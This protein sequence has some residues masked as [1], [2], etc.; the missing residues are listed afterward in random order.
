MVLSEPERKVFESPGGCH[1]DRVEQRAPRQ[2]R[3]PSDLTDAER[4]LSE[5]L[6][7]LAPLSGRSRKTDIT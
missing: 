3:Y 2:G 6:I 5:P 1:V 7:P 4:A